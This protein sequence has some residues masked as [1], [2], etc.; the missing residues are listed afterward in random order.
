MNKEDHKKTIS[1]K[2]LERIETEKVAPKSR[3]YFVGRN[4]IMW[5]LAGTSILVG[6]I[7]V[8]TIIFRT[9]NIWRILPPRMSYQEAVF[10]EFLN[11][12]PLL[13]LVVFVSFG[14]LAYMEI[15]HTRRGYKY[16]LSTLLLLMV[17]T[18]GVL[19]LVLYVLGSGY[20]VDQ[21]TSRHLSFQPKIE[22]L[23]RRYWLKPN[24]GFLVGEVG[25][26]TTE[27]FTLID[28]QGFIWSVTY[29]SSTP[30]DDKNFIVTTKK[31]GLLGNVVDL[32]NRRF[33][34]CRVK[35]L[36][37]KGRGLFLYRKLPPPIMYHDREQ[38]DER[39]IEVMR[40]NECEDVRPLLITQ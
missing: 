30:T 31:V 35:T 33:E 10:S 14:Y 32:E 26:T 16:E 19:G 34:A 22:V 18:S 5:S 25:T 8:S 17:V 15:R 4:I 20:I 3:Y 13:W 29:A 11:L 28:P 38:L 9:H 37:V 27:T 1:E 21:I 12:V 39:K 2:I 6:A 23:E 7:A 24:Q 36:E 40:N